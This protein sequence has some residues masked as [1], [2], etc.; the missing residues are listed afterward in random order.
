MHNVRVPKEI[1]ESEW[2]SYVCL[3]KT[4][5]NFTEKLGDKCPFCERKKKLYEEAVQAKE[6]GDMKKF[7]DLKRQSSSLFANEVG[8]IRCIERGHEEDGPKFW[9]F[10]IRADGMDPE[11]Q[12][13]KL[14]KNKKEECI[15]EG[16]EP[17]NILD[18]DEGYDLKVTISRVFDR[19]GKPTKKTTISISVF[20]SKKPITEDKEL[21][22]KWLDDKKIWSD[23]FVAK[24]YEYT[25]LILDGETPWFDRSKDKWV[26]YRDPKKLKEEQDAQEDNDADDAEKEMN[27]A[28]QKVSGQRT[29]SDEEDDSLPF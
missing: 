17:E 27:E 15:E 22:E 3:T 16:R 8:I 12:I 14:Y 28:P 21:K 11:N 13:R 26:A 10:N 1:S 20:G 7:E 18:L 4:H 6:D 25:Q 2:K 19:E 23:V 9:K 29:V 24:P 5:G